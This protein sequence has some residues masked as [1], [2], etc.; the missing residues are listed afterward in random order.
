MNTFLKSKFEYLPDEIILEIYRYLHC[1]HVLYSFYNINSRIN[2]AITDYCHHVILRRL[3]YK[4]F[5]YIYSNVLPKIGTFIISL[6]INRLQQTHFL[7]KFSLHMNKIFPNLQKLALDDWKNEE[8][9]SFIGNHLNQLQYLRTIIIRGLR[10]VNHTNL[11][12]HS[13]ED[14]KHLLEI[15]HKNTQ[16]E[17]IYFE[18]DCY[19]MKLSINQNNLI[20][21][22]NLIEMSISL[23]T[24]NDLISLAIIIPNIR[25]LHVV[26]E[27]LLPINKD[28]IPFQCL[29]H[30]SLDAID[31]YSTLDNISSILRLTPTIQQLSLTLTT[32]DERLIY[33]QHLFTLLS[34]QLFNN[35]NL[36]KS[37]KYAT[38][39]STSVDY[40]FDPKNILQSWNP[41]SIAY[42]INKDEKKSYILIHTLPYPSILL[43]LHS[44]LPNKFGINLGDQVY[45]NIQYLC[46]C[47]AKT[48]LETFTIIQHCR[49]IQDLNIQID[50]NKINLPGRINT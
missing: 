44:I 26:I 37:L 46:I 15:T 33:G 48:L 12:T 34:S 24:S 36:I 22:S 28:I 17:C 45:N 18:P 42:T 23:S 13:S 4:Q 11:I 25:R 20:T 43:N 47:H 21:H 41:I 14:Q 8:L 29:T 3:N 40:H 10:Q 7:N 6:T 2:H 30:F 9:F 32:R 31:F 38:Y 16:I 5:L 39:F 19:S 49:K 35:D 27:E 1:G 50:K